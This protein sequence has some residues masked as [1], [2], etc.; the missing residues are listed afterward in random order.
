MVEKAFNYLK[1]P[2]T[3]ITYNPPDRYFHKIIDVCEFK[4]Y[5]VVGGGFVDSAAT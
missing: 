2:P 5:I 1:N 4:V 3:I